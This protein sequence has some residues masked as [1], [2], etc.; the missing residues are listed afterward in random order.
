MKLS[1]LFNG[2]LLLANISI[3]KELFNYEL[4]RFVLVI[5]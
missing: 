5:F 1:Q 4:I 3:S 2:A